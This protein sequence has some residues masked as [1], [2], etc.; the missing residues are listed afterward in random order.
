MLKY[1]TQWVVTPEN[2]EQK[3]R[4]M[5]NGVVYYTAAA[6]R[7]PK[8]VK[9]DFYYM[10]AV[11]CSIFY[12]T[13]NK[14]EWL[15]TEN[16]VRLMQ[17]KGWLD[18]ALYASRRSPELLLEEISTYVPAKLE[19][20]EGEWPGIFERLAE[21]MDD[22]HSAK[23]G[24]VSY[25]SPVTLEIFWGASSWIMSSELVRELGPKDSLKHVLTLE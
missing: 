14:L 19:K 18:F 2:L 10:H 3:T 5:I 1:A 24:F 20:G 22:G 15:S 6:Q 17:W 16:K 25:H 4:E 12:P 8:Q 7:P 23:L 21:L 13:F 11:N 9:F